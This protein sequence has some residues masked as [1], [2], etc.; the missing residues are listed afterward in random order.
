MFAPEGSTRT[1]SVCAG[2][3]LQG[4]KDISFSNDGRKFLST[5]YDKVCRATSCSKRCVIVL[6]GKFFGTEESTTS[7]RLSL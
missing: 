4:V 7:R 2:T 5:S 3:T 1:I 6:F